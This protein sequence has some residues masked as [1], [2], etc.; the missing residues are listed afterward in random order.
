MAKEF[1]K[2]RGFIFLPLNLNSSCEKPFIDELKRLGQADDFFIIQIFIIDL[3]SVY[4]I[5]NHTVFT[6]E[7]NQE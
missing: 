1:L 2:G 6:H 4:V 5:H 3:D 7:I